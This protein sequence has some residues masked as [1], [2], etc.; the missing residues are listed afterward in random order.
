MK[1]SFNNIEN[2][3]KFT[4]EEKIQILKALDYA[5]KKHANQKRNT[6]EDYIIHPYYV[7]LILLEQNLLPCIIVAGILHDV[8][9]DTKTSFEDLEK[10]FG[11]DVAKTV[12]AVSKSRKIQLFQHESDEERKGLHHLYLDTIK[13][14]KSALIKIAD[15]LHNMRTLEFKEKDRQKIKSEETVKM[16]VPLAKEMWALKIAEELKELSLKYLTKDE[17][18]LAVAHSKLYEKEIIEKWHHKNAID[19]C[20]Y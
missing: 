1:Y 15:R 4:L 8:L 3:K 12:N 11:F 5:K 9:E 13:N 18:D 6:G 17:Y 16:Y 19:Q 20:I 14:P 7:A 2:F 10:E